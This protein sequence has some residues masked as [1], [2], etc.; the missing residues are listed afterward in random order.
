M[1]KNRQTSELINHISV[2]SSGSIVM[3]GDIIMPGGSKAATQSYVT[4][5]I[6]NLVDSSPATLDTL[7]EL[8]AALGD[9]PN[10]ATTVATS[11]GTKQP[12]LNGTGFVKATGTTISYDNSTYLTTSSAS[13][14]YLP[15]AGG[16]LTGALSGTSAIFSSTIQATQFSATATAGGSGAGIITQGGL[17]NY[18]ASGATDQKYWDIFAS[19]TQLSFRAVNDANS[20]ANNYMT[21]ARGSGYTISSVTF[22]NGTFNITNAATFSSSVTAGTDVT[23]NNGTLYVSAGSG[24]NYSSRLSTVYNF[25]YIETYLDSYAGAS[26]E[27]RLLFRTNSGGG[28]MSTKLTIA[29]SGAATFSSSVTATQYTATSTGGSGLR[30]YGASG[31]NQWD[32]YLNSTNLRFSD[33][34][35]TGNIVF[36]R[37]LNGTSANFSADIVLSAANPFI[38]GGTAAGGVGISNIGGQTYIKTYGASHATLANVTQFVNGSSTSFTISSAGAATFSSTLNTS[39]NIQI[40]GVSPLLIANA[41]STSYYGGLSIRLSGTEKARFA[42]NSTSGAYV[43]SPTFN[44]FG[45]LSDTINPLVITSTGAATFS[46]SVAIGTTAASGGVLRLPFDNAIRWRNSSNTADLGFYLGG[47]N[48]F[49]FDAGI[50]VAGAATFNGI[51]TMGTSGTNYI[52]MGV[53]PNSTSNSGEAW[54]GRASDRNSGTMTVQLGGGSASSRSFEVVDYAWSKVLFNVNSAGNLATTGRIHAGTYGNASRGSFLMGIENDSESKWSYLCS[55]QY[56]S[57]SNPSGYSVIGGYTSATE[58]KVIIGGSI[59]EANP[60]TSIEFWTHTAVT[61]ATGG[62]LRMRITTDGIKG[63]I[64]F[65]AQS[66]SGYR[67]RN[68]SDTANAGG[69]TRRGL[70]EGNANY[71]P[72]MWAETGYGLYFYSNG[73]ADIRAFF[74]TSGHFLPGANNTY[75]LGSSSNAWANIYTNDLHLS[76]INKPEGNDIDGTSGTWTIQEGANDLYIINNLNNKRFKIKL[77]EII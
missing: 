27:G 14:T 21:V 66:S 1:S 68:S 71:D 13:S 62:T 53:F 4:T 34:T 45:I 10:F 77:E 61:H 67:I 43:Y 44:G 57:S 12:Q 56:N 65:D 74:N 22:P 33:N 40:D 37:P 35:G 70:W 46:S 24:L 9:D 2:D 76:N 47:T 30:V 73:S 16:T 72:G 25:P 5:A 3:T 32:M 41:S 42:A 38:Y 17:T 11:I 8:A 26:Y 18:F 51:V 64:Y 55:T 58:N 31:T 29:N 7:N 60:C 15:L 39:G 52:R 69:F 19:T 23:L 75:N 20:L 48:L 28:A 6:S 63:A 49:T 59:Y 36:D 50:S 54:I